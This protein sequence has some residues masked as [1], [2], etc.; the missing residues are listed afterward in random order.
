MNMSWFCVPRNSCL[1]DDLRHSIVPWIVIVFFPSLSLSPLGFN[2]KRQHYCYV[3]C[4]HMNFC[5]SQHNS[6]VLEQNLDDEF[7]T[8]ITWSIQRACL[9]LWIE[10]DVYKIAMQNLR[11]FDR[12]STW[13]HQI[14]SF[15]IWNVQILNAKYND[16]LIK[17][18]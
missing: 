15:H 3:D 10:N 5:D 18:D 14:E 12:K 9:S 2:V 6:W 13:K 8:Q 16:Y 11:G 7:S 1:I 4:I 17:S